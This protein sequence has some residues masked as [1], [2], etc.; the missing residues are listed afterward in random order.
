MN[1]TAVKSPSIAIAGHLVMDEIIFRGKEPTRALGG[2]SYNLAAM[3]SIMKTGKILPVCE[4]GEDI[5]ELFQSVYGR[6]GNIDISAVRYTSL[7]NVVNRLVYSDS[8]HRDEWNSRVP[9]PL[10]LDAVGSDMDA[11][12]INHIS[13]GDILPD[14][15][16]AFRRRFKGI[17]Y[18]DYHSLSLG[19]GP[20]GKRYYRHRPDWRDYLAGVD[21]IQMNREELCS[22]TG[23]IGEL[24]AD[25][26][27]TCRRLHDAGPRTAIITL[28]AGGS[29]LC[30]DSGANVYFIP[31]VDIPDPVDP[32]G[33][34]DTLASVC[35]YNYLI[36][37]QMVLSTIQANR[38][39]AAKAAFSGLD[40]FKDMESIMINI[41]P[42][43]EPVR[44]D[45]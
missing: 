24:P 30:M 34:G 36:S 11:L 7:P 25:I 15:L 26:A 42:V 3:T 20:E 6:F 10:R 13:G 14:E 4:L 16:T 45:I 18:C 31:P 17:I 12:L 19:R 23:E 43:V 44:L 39:A 41:G 27:R 28:G 21:I 8:E 38:W 35:L 9:D 1:S 22:I 2:I 37:G 40:G 32:T 5:R 29:V 33:C